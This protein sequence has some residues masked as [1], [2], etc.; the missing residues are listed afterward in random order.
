MRFETDEQSRTI[1]RW[2]RLAIQLNGLADSG[3]CA[4]LTTTVVQNELRDGDVFALLTRELPGE[5]WTIVRLTDVDRH[6]L[7]KI[8]Q[9]L[10]A[11]YDRRQFHVEQSGLALLVAYLLHSIDNAHAVLPV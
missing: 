5:V 11:A 6:T 1:Q 3:K 9:A 4:H 2:T 10:A 7:S 8:W